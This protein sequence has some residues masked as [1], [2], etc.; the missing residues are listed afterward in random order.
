MSCPNFSYERRC[1]LV[2]NEDYD[3]GNCPKDGNYS[4]RDR[5]YPSSYL[6]DYED[7]FSTI[8]IVITS[9][10]YSDACID[11]VDDNRL[12]SELSCSDYHFARLT[13]DELYDE[14]NYYFEGNMS[15]RMMLRHLK[16]LD[17]RKDDYQSKLSYAV[18]DI[19]EEV[20][21][22]EVEMANKILDNIKKEYGFKELRC[23]G[24]FS[25]GEA[26]YSFVA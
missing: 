19:L 12:V 5:S 24:I 14:L 18:D 21:E 15:K 16:G 23:T 4:D 13:R 11:I 9:G 7:M 8:A 10:H 22:R 6:E 2:T 26:V 1:I 20:R 25:N 3:C 17:C